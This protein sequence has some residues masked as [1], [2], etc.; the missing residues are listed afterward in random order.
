MSDRFLIKIVTLF[1]VNLLSAKTVFLGSSVLYAGTEEKSVK[2]PDA[3]LEYDHIFSIKPS[4]T[5]TSGYYLEL[6][7]RNF[8]VKGVMP[9]CFQDYVE[10]FLG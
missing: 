2:F 10:V 7:W 8:S 5:N 6:E 9:S 4:K 1:L 3:Y